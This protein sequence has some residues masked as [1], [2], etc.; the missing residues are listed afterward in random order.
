MAHGGSARAENGDIG[1]PLALQAKLGPFQA[2]A[3]FI[4]RD[5]GKGRA[6]SRQRRRGR[7]FQRRDL[8]VAESLEL[9]R[10]RGVMAVTVDDHCAASF[11]VCA[12]RMASSMAARLVSRAP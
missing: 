6:G 9:G 11:L 8:A 7:A 10:R 3:D 12:A 2:G 4:V 1:A 5:P